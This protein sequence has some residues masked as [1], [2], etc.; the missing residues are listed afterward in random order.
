M[1]VLPGS[2]DYLYYNGILD[3]I[4]YEAYASGMPAVRMNS[5][6]PM[7]GSGN[8]AQNSY[9]EYASNYFNGGESAYSA[10]NYEAVYGNQSDTFTRTGKGNKNEEKSYRESLISGFEKTK[11][12]VNS[13]PS[14]VKGLIGAAVMLGTLFLLIKGKKKP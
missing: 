4:P 9:M 2:L 1:T 13:T 10:P 3:H 14:V 12:A 5:M 7:P 6:P 8:Y 11:N